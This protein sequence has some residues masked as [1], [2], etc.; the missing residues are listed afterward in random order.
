MS[1]ESPE[2]D[3]AVAFGDATFSAGRLAS[4]NSLFR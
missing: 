3:F 2:A 4:R 1:L